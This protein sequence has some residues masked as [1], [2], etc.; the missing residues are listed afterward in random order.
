MEPVNVFAQRFQALS[1]SRTYLFEVRREA[2]CERGPIVAVLGGR[3]A[4]RQPKGA[5]ESPTRTI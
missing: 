5:G 2:Y 3:T 1:V 4:P